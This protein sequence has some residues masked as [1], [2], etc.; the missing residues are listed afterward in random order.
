MKQR[1]LWQ[2]KRLSEGRQKLPVLKLMIG[3][4]ARL[5]AMQT[6]DLKQVMRAAPYD[7]W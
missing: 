4:A 7:P 5:S 3:L 2:E 1:Q 6:Q